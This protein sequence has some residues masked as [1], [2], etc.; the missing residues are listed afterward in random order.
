MPIGEARSSGRDEATVSIADD[1]IPILDAVLEAG[2]I[3]EAL[4]T[5]TRAVM[6]TIAE[7][8]D[9]VVA[10]YVPAYAAMR[11][12]CNAVPECESAIK[13]LRNDLF[14]EIGKVTGIW[15]LVSAI[16]D[17]Y[18]RIPAAIRTV[19]GKLATDT[20]NKAKEVMDTVTGVW[21]DPG[22]LW[23]LATTPDNWFD[24]ARL[25]TDLAANASEQIAKWFA[26]GF[27][28]L[29]GAAEDLPVIGPIVKGLVDAGKVI[30]DTYKDVESFVA[31]LG[32]GVFGVIGDVAEAGWEIVSAP[33]EAVGDWLGL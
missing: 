30:W 11:L 16:R 32:E 13:T 31:D 7:A 21:A 28:D 33:V 10:Q 29:L 19:V 24:T 9:D 17:A 6:D 2:E 25:G 8:G 14:A 18:L 27:E 12:Q 5:S 3:V 23:E 20:I 15:A 4:E 26:D 22:E 1:I